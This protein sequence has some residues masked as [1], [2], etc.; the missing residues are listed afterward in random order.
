MNIFGEKLLICAKQNSIDHDVWDYLEDLGVR[1]KLARR[2]EKK[3]IEYYEIQHKVVLID[4]GGYFSSIA[5]QASLNILG[6]V[7]DTE[8]GLQKYTSNI[9]G[10]QYPLFSVARNPLKKNEDHLVGK[11]IVFG[12][13]YIL[14]KRNLLLQYMTVACIGY[15]KIGRGICSKLREMGLRPYVL[16]LNNILA[17]EAI[18]EGCIYLPDKNFAEMDVIFCATGSQSLNVLDFRNINDGTYLVSA[19]S[20]DD[21]FDLSYLEE[22]YEKHEFDEFIT[23]Y[24]NDRNFF[25][26][27]NK[28]TPTNFAIGASLGDYI[29]LVHAAIMVAI[30]KILT[31]HQ[32]YKENTKK[33]YELTECE[34]K[35]I[36][37]NWLQKIHKYNRLS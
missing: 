26:L 29:L 11:D 37:S 12:A 28:G 36:A 17:I 9:D 20:S 32:N 18:R 31:S 33:V 27:L 13:D 4:I 2:D 16:E 30:K 25:Y 1:L 22:E 14:H 24:R 19:T 23:E 7:E 34:N 5:Q 6:I 21:E 10:L 35:M 8:N 15:G 3:T